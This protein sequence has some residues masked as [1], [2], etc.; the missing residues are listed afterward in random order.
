MEV[1]VNTTCIYTE[2][3]SQ[4][5]GG[6][7]EYKDVCTC[8]IV[9]IFKPSHL[10][11]IFGTGRASPHWAVVPDS[12]CIRENKHVTMQNMKLL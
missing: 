12:S 4:M 9:I 3:T 7:M 5:K 2:C 10:N 1:D 11:N 6:E 8:H